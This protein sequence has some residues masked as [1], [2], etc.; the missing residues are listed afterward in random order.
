VLA[1]IAEA[2]PK[3][4]NFKRALGRSGESGPRYVF[5]PPNDANGEITFTVLAFDIPTA[6]ADLKTIAVGGTLAKEP[7]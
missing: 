5:A 4:P 6:P 3:H 1:K 2:V 7:N